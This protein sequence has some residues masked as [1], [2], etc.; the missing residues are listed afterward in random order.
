MQKKVYISY[1]LL[2]QENYNIHRILISEIKK[3]YM[4]SMDM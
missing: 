1:N 2:N 3:F 4:L